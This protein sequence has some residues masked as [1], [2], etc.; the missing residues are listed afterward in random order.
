MR[1]EELVGRNY[2][3]LNDNDLHIWKYILR[4]QEAC[5]KMSI[6]DLASACNLSHTTVLRF[7]RKLG[8]DGYSE[9]KLCLKWADEKETEI[10]LEEI[11]LC[12]EDI[13]R[14]MAYIRK[15][16]CSDLFELFDRSE[17]I[18]AY[19]TGQV[20]KSAAEEMKKNFIYLNLEIVNLDGEAE[21]RIML[22]YSGEKDLFLLFSH[23]G[24]NP[25]ALEIAEKLKKKG[26]SIVSITRV[27]NNK[28]SRI[29]DVSLFFYNHLVKTDN[30]DNELYMTSQYFMISELLMLKYMEYRKGNV[31]ARTK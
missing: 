22:N 17:H 11:D 6:Q 28:L 15:R 27:G 18:Y 23:S 9:L 20:Q 8:L 24:E 12:C 4:H 2:D 31:S 5:K 19:G 1:L 21:M 29:S 14:T 26:S 7:A 13:N 16:D 30:W 3:K 10:G 25:F